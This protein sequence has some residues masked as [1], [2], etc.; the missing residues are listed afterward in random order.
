MDPKLQS[1]IVVI[2][3]ILFVVYRRV[4]RNFGRQR[5]SEGRLKFRI[6][7]LSV[8]GA[9]LLILSIR[10]PPAL[11]ALAGGVVGG[12]ALATVGLRHT[13]FEN[14]SE[15]RFY[16][17]HTYFGLVVTALFLVRISYRL[18][19]VQPAAADGQ[20]PISNLQH[21][22]LNTLVFGLVIGYYT[23]FNLGV[24]R[25]SQLT[26]LQGAPPAPEPTTPA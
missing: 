19:M 20:S 24:L 18:L 1:R 22:P 10:F 25:R 7:L 9:L 4:R 5:V 3:L 15:G 12:L 17:T 11:A 16:T 14:T 26:P 21:S 6:G 8:I 23:C 2:A 13:Q